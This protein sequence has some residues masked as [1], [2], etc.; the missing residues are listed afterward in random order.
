MPVMDWYATLSTRLNI[1][2]RMLSLIFPHKKSQDAF[3]LCFYR[4]LA[5]E[6]RIEAKPHQH[7][8]QWQLPSNLQFFI[9]WSD[10][11]VVVKIPWTSSKPGNAGLNSSIFSRYNLDYWLLCVASGIKFFNIKK[12]FNFANMFCNNFW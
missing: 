1:K 7:R 4:R 5:V 12:I 2:V 8:W 10:E 6:E 3:Y 9:P 11:W